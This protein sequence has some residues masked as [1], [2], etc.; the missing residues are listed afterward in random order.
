MRPG[1]AVLLACLAALGSAC[2][3]RGDPLPP[4][5]RTPPAPQ[6]F[7][8]AQRGAALEVE[9]VAPA[10]SVDGV[11]Y[12][13]V[14]VEFLYVEGLSDLEKTGQRLSV[15]A[16]PGRRVSGTLP[17]PPPGTTVRAAARAVD[18]REE[19]A[20]TMTAALVAQAPL[21]PPRELSATLSEGGIAL[22]WR[23]RRPEPAPDPVL[24]GAAPSLAPGATS[25]ARP[26]EP[27]ASSAAP[28][29]PATVPP[30]KPNEPASSPERTEGA[31]DD[32]TETPGSEA[33]PAEPRSAGFLVYRRLGAAVQGTPILAEPA[34]R[35]SLFD[36]AVPLGVTACYVVRAVASTDPLIESAPSNEA[37]VEVRDVVGPATPAGLAVLAREVG[38]EVLWAP[39]A[40]ADLAGYRIYRE[41]EGGAP[42]RVAE[43][44]AHRSS[45][46]DET[47]SR[48]VVY[49]YT[50]SA[51]DQAGNESDR[52]EPVEAI[53]P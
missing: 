7:R 34:E 42:E 22:S 16:T 53:R 5:R 24:P 10:A 31:E 13:S 33:E 28:L 38:L 8:L 9:A 51:F 4:L 44:E 15:L 11:T 2:G 3:H 6:A 39:G 1:P 18:G 14:V 25:P 17:L 20:R 29:P 43:V 27:P 35:R 36:G 26:G 46:L 45:W 48:G 52:P 21:E 23:G 19:G 40:E 41:V 30:R 37:C 32:A 47:A 50:V 49:R 12:A